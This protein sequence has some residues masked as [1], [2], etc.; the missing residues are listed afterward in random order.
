MSSRINCPNCLKEFMTRRGL[1]KHLLAVHQ[2]VFIG[3]SDRTRT[4]DPDELDTAMQ[5]H[6]KGQFKERLHPVSQP[7][8][9]AGRPSQILKVKIVKPV[10]PKAGPVA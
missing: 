8:A 7:S 6:K 9:A 1:Q 3:F 5:K 10:K 2:Q 4:L